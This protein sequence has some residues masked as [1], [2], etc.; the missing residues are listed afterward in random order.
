M[1]SRVV[2]VASALMIPLAVGIVEASPAQAAVWDCYT[3]SSPA[4]PYGYC[5]SG[6]SL[7]FKANMNCRTV[8]PFLQWTKVSS[9]PAMRVGGNKPSVV[10]GCGF[11]QELYG[12]IWMTGS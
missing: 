6:N 8:W 1:K 12:S 7:Y 2:A 4:G 5:G 10:P 9:G 3:G 11:G